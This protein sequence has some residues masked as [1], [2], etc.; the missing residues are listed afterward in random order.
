MEP[1]DK[2]PAVDT[3]IR[4]LKLLT[5][6]EYRESTLTS[7]TNALEINKSTCLRILKTL[8]YHSFLTYSETSKTYSL[9][10]ALIPLGQRA[11]ELN[12]YIVTA[13]AY[14]PELARLGLTSVLVKKGRGSDLIY[15]AKQEP[16]LKIRL[17]ISTGD[18]FPIPAGAL[19]KCFFSYL[20]EEEADQIVEQELNNGVL[21]IYTP[22]SIVTLDQLKEQRTVIRQEGIAESH[23]EYSLGFSGFACP[24]FDSSRNIVLALGV[25]LPSSFRNYMEVG[26]LKD[27]VRK[28]AQDITDAISD[29]S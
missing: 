15:V 2:V 21:P 24:I 19:G 29:I 11:K 26:E 1:K 9:G 13:S 4:M 7:L 28:T 16:P 22:N 14:L 25:Y 8:E 6:E 18:S 27:A 5:K 23:E 20:P 12:D 3:A 10:T 17:T